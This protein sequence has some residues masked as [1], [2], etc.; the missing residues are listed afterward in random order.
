MTSEPTLTRDAP[1]RGAALDHGPALIVLLTC[2]AP[3]AGSSRHA[4][5][6]L[7]EVA[8]GRAAAPRTVRGD[9]RLE[10]GLADP[11]M[12]RSHARLVRDLDRWVVEDAGS[13]NGVRVNGAP[14]PRAV[15]EDGDLLELGHTLCLFRAAAAGPQILPADCAR[16]ELGP[17]GLAT[18][19]PPLA[20][21]FDDLAA[22]VRTDAA[23]LILGETGT[24]KEL[25]ARAAH[26]LAGRTGAFVAVNCGALPETLAESEL[27]GYRKG[28]F[29]GATQDR[30]GLVRSADHG[31][32]FLDEI[33]D[34]APASQATLLRV[35]Q[36]REVTPVGA[37][38]PVPVDVQIVAAT[39]HDLDARVAEG[40]FRK[41][42]H[43]RL[44]AFT[45]RL[46]PLRAR[47]EDL[48]VVIGDLVARG[49]PAIRLSTEAATA[50]ARY[51]WPANVRELAAAL[52]VAGALARGEPIQ[53]EHLP[54]AIRG[55]PAPD[56][57]D[58]DPRR[59]ELI[60]LL[61]EHAGNV[62]AIARAARRSRVQ[63]HR[64][65]RRYDLDAARY[66]R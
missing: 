4:L 50:L 57:G 36:E 26:R 62:S 51:A 44:A 40:R 20:A 54:E 2:D 61:V 15:L 21:A 9:R 17:P 30:L 65:L 45:L 10:L 47:R 32:V 29:S 12:S 39:H 31:T 52:V 5:A 64:W 66:R 11:R 16:A 3:T 35:L 38:T 8:L 27:F 19:S 55:G 60:A 48:G 1:Y 13:R 63:V 22:V 7:D 18:F 33:G 34:L 58:D 14:L 23:I 43:A 46:P 56:A 28:A 37:A 6:G 41:D 24:G 59:A 42:L 53:P 25:V 49:D